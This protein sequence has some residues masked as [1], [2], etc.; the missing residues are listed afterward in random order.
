MAVKVSTIIAAYNA[1][2]TIAETVESALAQR[3]EGNEV[4]VVNDG[5]TD[6]TAAILRGYDGRIRVVTQSNRGAAAARNAGVAQSGG[7][8]LAFLD[9]DDV[10]LP[11]KLATMIAVLERNPAA[12]L[13]FSEFGFIDDN[14]NE[15]RTSSIGK[16]PSFKELMTKRPFPAA[17]MSEGIMTSTWVLPRSSFDAVG[18]FC[19]VFEREACEDCW[20]LVLLR[21]LG[22]FV[23]VPEKLTCYRIAHPIEMADKYGPGVEI[24]IALVKRHYGLCGRTLIRNAKN[25]KCRWLLT[26]IAHQMDRGDRLGALSSLAQIARLRPLYFLTR[27]FSD[28]LRLPHNTKRIRE[29]MLARLRS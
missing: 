1:E 22:E 2:R 8:Y 14:G 18:G 28:R 12:S 11:G 13:A 3:Y 6:S 16:L 9:S 29:L 27:E 15:Y 19:E 24:F 20:M 7:K 25:V 21:D 17:S 10:W 5:S 4:V 26:K 23:Y